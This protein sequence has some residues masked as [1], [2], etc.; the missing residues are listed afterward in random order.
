MVL[1]SSQFFSVFDFCA[2]S[3]F[4]GRERP[5]SWSNQYYRSSRGGCALGL[6]CCFLV[7]ELRHQYCHC[8]FVFVLLCRSCQSPLHFLSR[9]RTPIIGHCCSAR[10]CSPWCASSSAASPWASPSCCSHLSSL[11]SYYLI[12]L[13]GIIR[14]EPWRYIAWSILPSSL[15]LAQ[16]FFETSRS[17]VTRYQIHY[18]LSS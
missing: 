3:D 6:R 9:S 14:W 5:I 7:R 18:S 4:V 8:C 15:L 17:P 13:F 12:H 1:L 10:S 11:L 2:R 16:T